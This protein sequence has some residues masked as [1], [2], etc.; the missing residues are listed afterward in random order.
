MFCLS[1]IIPVFNGASSI[2]NT[3]KSIVTNEIISEYS[4]KI[5][6]IVVDDGS[7][8]GTKSVVLDTISDFTEFKITYYY[9]S[10]RGSSVARNKGLELAVGTYI[11]FFDA[12]D[13]LLDDDIRSIFKYL[14][15]EK[16]EVI[17]FKNAQ[18]K[19]D[20]I[21]NYG[22]DFSIV[23]NKILS[24]V[25]AF[26]NGYNP[27]SVCCLIIKKDLFYKFNI[28]FYPGITHQDVELTAKLIINVNSVIFLDSA[29]Y[30]YIY[31][32]ESVSK[33]KN[34]LK[35]IK[36]QLDNLI[37]AK[38][39]RDYS[40][41]LDVEKKFQILKIVNNIVWNYIY[42]LFISRNSIDYVMLVLFK[43]ELFYSGCYP[44]TK[45]V[46]TRFQK[47]TRPLFNNKFILNIFL[48]FV[49]KVVK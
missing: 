21:Y 27:S 48:F 10:N 46:Q 17:A 7:T 16:V 20:K 43:K 31:N 30:G 33:S 24:G 47:I 37:V 22:C 6:L 9:Q 13:I 29:P 38:S 28:K 11:W 15:N 19:D 25:A 5:E 1:I 34:K 42:N 35:Y 4:E 32:P 8:D 45:D 41:S 3:I 49:Y 39:L 2:Y 44:L 12:D 14:L 18:I 26:E 40:N 23:K 36:Y